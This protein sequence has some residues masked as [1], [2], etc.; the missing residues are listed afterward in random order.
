MTSFV[1]FCRFLPVRAK[2]V[3]LLAGPDPICSHEATVQPAVK[4]AHTMLQNLCPGKGSKLLVV[5]ALFIST[6]TAFGQSA[7]FTYQ[8]RL[9]D[10]GTAANGI[11]DMQFKLYDTAT[12]GTGTQIGSTITKSTVMVT[13][14]VFTVD[15]DFG[16]SAFPGAGRFLGI[17]VRANGSLNP[18]TEL[19]PRQPVT[20]T[21]YALRTISAAL[22]DNATNATQLGGV[23]ANQYVQTSDSR[24]SDPRPPTIGSSNYIQNT[25]SAQAGSNFNI[26]GSGTA[27]GTLRADVVN[28]ATQYNIGGNRVLSTA[29]ANSLFAGLGS[30]QANTTGGSNSFFGT[31]A[32]NS[33]T[34]GGNNSFF[35]ST[36]GYSNTT[37]A[38]NSFF[39]DGAGRHS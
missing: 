26:S 14:G 12:V 16:S 29:G 32:G 5:L 20:S 6:S 30:G 11:Y 28:A 10:G 21:P 18:Y 34:S 17:A 39:G 22:A 24:L 38:S 35:G 1:L 25:T 19:A 37:G 8:G 2:V 3:W 4:E 31:L 15:L 23:T 7:A 33:N 36:A 13:S 27:G 9:A